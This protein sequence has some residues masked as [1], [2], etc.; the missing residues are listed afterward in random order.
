MQIVGPN[1]Q[2][3]RQLNT[4]FWMGWL[5]AACCNSSPSASA[6]RTRAWML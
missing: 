4:D 3:K 1:L 6:R 2:A 5:S